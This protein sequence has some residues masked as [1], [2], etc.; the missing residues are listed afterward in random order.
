[1]SQRPR[2]GFFSDER[3]THSMARALLVVT[4]AF[5]LFLISAET[6]YHTVVSGAAWA[7]LTMME[8][9]FVVWTAG[10]RIAQYLAPVVTAGI[11]AVRDAIRARRD[12][13]DGIEYTP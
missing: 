1:M 12:P 3:E 7:I 10:P 2:T 6:F 5:I 4:T 11:Q 9:A 8:G 13:D